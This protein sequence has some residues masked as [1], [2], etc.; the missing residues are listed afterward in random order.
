MVDELPSLQGVA[1]ATGTLWQPLAG[2]HDESMHWVDGEQV[3]A[4]PATHAK[5]WQVSVPL[6]AFPSSQ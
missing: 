6:H 3:G 2:L 5:L 4:V 1:S